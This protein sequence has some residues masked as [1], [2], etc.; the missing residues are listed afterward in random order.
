MKL[1]IL[2]T[3][4]KEGLDSVGRV[5]GDGASALPIL[6]NF[7]FETV[8]GKIKLSATNLELAITCF[9]SGKIIE[10]GG[11]TIPLGIF[12][13]IIGN[14]QS[15]RISLETEND[16]LVIKTDN[17]EAKIQ[18]I[19]KEEFPIIPSMANGVASMDIDLESVRG[20][21]SFVV[22]AA[23]VSELRPEMNGV[24]FDFGTNMVK[25][26]ATDSFR[27]AEMTIS[28]S[29]FKTEISEPFRIIIPL[30]TINEVVRI[31]K[32]VGEKI[33]IQFDNNQ[34]LFRDGNL[35]MISRLVSGDFPEYQPIIPQDAETEVVL[36]KNELVNAL[37]LASSFT[38]RLNEVKFSAGDKSKSVEVFSSS[39]N[40][41]ENKY[42]IPAKAKGSSVEV[43]FN[44]RFFLDGLKSFNSENVKI[45]LNGDDKPAIIK[46]PN[47]NSCFY[48]LMPIKNS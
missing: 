48:I 19:K 47:D 32:G 37:K 6:K 29:R 35:E 34:I 4:L 14:L 18:G 12:N 23:Q 20:A 39:H 7:L 16:N 17:Y 27:L 1:I 13:S 15:E 46:S 3:N 9:V 24:L 30:K 42:L 26:A 11:I 28:D 43:V 5:A 10:D 38:D 31:F 8:D 21:F 41:G 33:T 22:G 25:L 44:W 36:D 2:K 40:L 45:G